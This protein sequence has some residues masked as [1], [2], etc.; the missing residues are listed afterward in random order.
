MAF[1]IELEVT[2]SRLLS[3]IV[4]CKKL[5]IGTLV[6]TRPLLKDK[7][8]KDCKYASQKKSRNTSAVVD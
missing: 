6:T 2:K 8:F 3:L 1:M 7:T 4:T 5:L